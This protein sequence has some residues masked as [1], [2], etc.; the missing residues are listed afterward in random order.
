MHSTVWWLQ[1]KETQEVSSEVI[2]VSKLITIYSVHTMCC[3]RLY[4]N[5]VPEI[6][7]VYYPHYIDED[8]INKFR[9]LSDLLAMT[10][11]SM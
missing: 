8:A 3:E 10:G 11:F 9:A 4:K 5:G 1:K 2:G 6:L 7:W